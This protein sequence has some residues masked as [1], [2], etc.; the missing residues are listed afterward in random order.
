MEEWRESLAKNYP[1]VEKQLPDGA[2][3][4]DAMRIL[5]TL[6]ASAPEEPQS[7]GDHLGRI[8]QSADRH[9]N[10]VALST[11]MAE[12]LGICAKA[13]REVT[14]LR[15]VALDSVSPQHVVVPLDG[16]ALMLPFNWTHPERRHQPD[17]GAV[18]LAETDVPDGFKLTRDNTSQQVCERHFLRGV[19]Y[20][21]SPGISV[22]L[23]VALN[24]DDR[25]AKKVFA[26]MVEVRV[27][28][29][30]WADAPVKWIERKRVDIG[31]GDEHF[32]HHGVTAGQDGRAGSYLIARLGPIVASVFT[33]DVDDA[34]SLALFKRQWSKVEA[35]IANDVL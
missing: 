11:L 28:G 13:V 29:A 15:V 1:K 33:D 12:A 7:Y 27:S 2:S 24:N 19:R 32:A 30:A 10:A 21:Y 22:H 18:A 26:M 3:I 5:E 14:D 34:T 6:R 23:A 8:M 20:G 35:A 9:P 31:V 17:V 25:L 16:Y 4:D